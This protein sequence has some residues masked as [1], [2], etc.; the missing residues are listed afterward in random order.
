MEELSESMQVIRTLKQIMV[1]M[2]KS[3]EGQYKDMNITGP[4][5][6]VVGTLAHCGEMKISDLSERLQLSNSTV[7]GILDRLEKQNL[8]ERVRSKEDRRVVYIRLTSEIKK[9]AEQRFK[10]IEKNIEIK[11][12]KATPEEIDKIL[13]GLN[14]LKKMLQ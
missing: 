1:S 3:L 10:D 14:I 13:E 11:M 12:S 4:Q 7:S 9:I 8:I 6:M 5:G 2:K